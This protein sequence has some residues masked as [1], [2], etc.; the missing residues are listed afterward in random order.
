MRVVLNSYAC[1]GDNPLAKVRGLSP[2]TA[3]KP[4]DLQWLN[5]TVC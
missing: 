3:I 1:T 2:R 4:G 5:H